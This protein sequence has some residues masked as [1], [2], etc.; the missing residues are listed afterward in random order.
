MV[1]KWAWPPCLAS[2]GPRYASWPMAIPSNT[3]SIT[4]IF[5]NRFYLIW[6]ENW[7]RLFKNTTT[8]KWP[9]NSY[10]SPP[11][12]KWQHY[13][14][15]L[16]LAKC[17]IWKPQDHLCVFMNPQYTRKMYCCMRLCVKHLMHL[18]LE[19]LKTTRPAI[20]LGILPLSSNATSAN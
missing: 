9:T 2:P 8:I 15:S 11:P 4:G 12:L 18:F 20:L 7:G 5:Q 6:Y 13:L 16:C 14:R 10:A 3:D 17:I 1:Q 19:E